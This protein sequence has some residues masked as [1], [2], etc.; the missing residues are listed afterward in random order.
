GRSMYRPISRRSSQPPQLIETLL[1]PSNG[2]PQPEEPPAESRD[3]TPIQK[4][5]WSYI[6]MILKVHDMEGDL[7]ELHQSNTEDK[8]LGSGVK[9][10]IIPK[11]EHCKMPETGM[12]SIRI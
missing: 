1:E 6:S 11:V 5:E 4:A 2:E 3:P 7:Q 8:D 12:L 9:A 10:K